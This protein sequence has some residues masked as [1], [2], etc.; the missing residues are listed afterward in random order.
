MKNK[1]Y[2]PFLEYINNQWIE[3]FEN[4]ILCLDKVNIKFRTT[5]SL[6]N[7][8]RVLKNEF[9]H[10]GEIDNIIYIDTLTT[11]YKEQNEYFEKEI[12][13]QPI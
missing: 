6:E 5:N 3:F 2:K 8:N 12:K 10:K 7:F 1:I 4:K 9:D 13:K 11:L